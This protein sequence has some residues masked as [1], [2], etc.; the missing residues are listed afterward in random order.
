MRCV[1]LGG[2]GFLGRNLAF[3]L[4]SEGH[5]VRVF[6]RFPISKDFE[7]AGIEAIAGDF[8]NQGD[9]EQAFEGQEAVFHLISTTL[10]SSSNE[11]PAFDVSSNVCGSIR[12]FELAAKLGL[13]VFFSS[14]GG[15]VYGPP[16]EVPIPE[17]H[18]KAPICS[19]GISKLAIEHYL[20]LF[21][22]LHGLRSVTLRIANPYGRR[23][24]INASQGAI[25]VFFAKA[26]AGQ[27]IEVWGDGSV[28]RDFV[29]IDDV[30]EAF[31]A[32]LDYQGPER[33][34]NIG[35][36]SGSSLREILEAI[37]AVLGKNLDVRYSPGRATD[38]PVNVLDS[39]RAREI[40]GWEAR[41]SL[42]EGIARMAQSRGEG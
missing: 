13:R 31:L 26:M 17:A 10:P 32:A 38:V 9:L 36:G 16:K 14:S 12:V 2:A 30:S 1:I 20:H 11:D 6:D 15:T 35:S 19:Y 41:T 33:T 24:H 34:F 5:S 29:F 7:A 21:E 23:A 28:V 27:P 40:L 22:V 42:S 37:E 4:K 3:R 8:Q 39:S 18:P 25:D